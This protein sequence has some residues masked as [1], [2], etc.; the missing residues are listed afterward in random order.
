MTNEEILDRL[1]L[2]KMPPPRIAG[3]EDSYKQM[4]S[5]SQLLNFK[6]A[7]QLVDPIETA[8]FEPYIP[9]DVVIDQS[10]DP[11]SFSPDTSR[12][13]MLRTDIPI[14]SNLRV[15]RSTGISRT[16]NAH[17]HYRWL[18]QELSRHMLEFG[19]RAVSPPLIFRTHG[20]DKTA[21]LLGMIIKL[22]PRK[23]HENAGANWAL[24][25]E[26][27]PE[28]VLDENETLDDVK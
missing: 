18:G 23:R 15:F 27:V 4:P 17:N 24:M 8:A 12:A 19:S 11:R 16:P 28:V 13:I 6:K 9:D 7:L 1:G 3:L 26:R 10:I 5:G 21:P 25:G 2:D 14:P 20:A 22:D